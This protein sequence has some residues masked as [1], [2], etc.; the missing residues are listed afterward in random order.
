MG[1]ELC[2]YISCSLMKLL[3]LKCGNPGKGEEWHLSLFFRSL[4][5]FT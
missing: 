1:G 3:I 4:V 5:S 2:G